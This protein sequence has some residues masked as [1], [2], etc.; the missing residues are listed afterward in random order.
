MWCGASMADGNDAGDDDYVD[1][2]DEDVT[3]SLRACPTTTIKQ[4]LTHPASSSNAYGSV[5]LCTHLT[6]MYKS[7]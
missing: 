3:V 4:T 6:C 1:D 5:T 7:S 2:N